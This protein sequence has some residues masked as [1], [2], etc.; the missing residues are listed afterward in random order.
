VFSLAQLQE[1]GA[2]RVI[3]TNQIAALGT[4][5]SQLIGEKKDVA[6]RYWTGMEDRSRK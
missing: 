4:G 5:R 3:H 2:E 1:L 6:E